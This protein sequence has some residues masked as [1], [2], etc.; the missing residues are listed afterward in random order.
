MEIRDGYLVGHSRRVASISLK[1]SRKIGF[2][3]NLR[4]KILLGG[5]FHDIGRLGIRDDIAG[6]NGPLNEE[7][8][9]HLKKHPLISVEIL[10]PV[11][12][13]SF[14]LKTIK[15][16][17][18]R[19]DGKGYP[20][21]LKGEEI[22]LGARIMAVADAYEAMTSHRPHRKALL[23]KIAIEEIEKNAG[24]QFDPEIVKIFLSLP[25]ADLLPENIL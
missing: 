25:P 1:I 16:H 2:A 23:P 3:D 4:K 13:D 15:H 17:H 21:G 14:I 11:I 19:F 7:E 8:F 9:G 24:T 10:S 20:L 5:N 6:K 22:P 18:E 12:K